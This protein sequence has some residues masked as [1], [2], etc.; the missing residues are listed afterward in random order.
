MTAKAKF[1]RWVWRYNAVGIA[2]SMSLSVMLLSLAL[3]EIATDLTRERH[4]TGLTH[5]GA[6]Q[7]ANTRR[8]F[9]PPR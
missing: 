9:G 5:I 7:Q 8:S 1:F 3:Y 6:E 4:A 2:I